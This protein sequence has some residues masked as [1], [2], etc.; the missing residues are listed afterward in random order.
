MRISQQIVLT[1]IIVYIVGYF[2]M[3]IDK[4]IIFHVHPRHSY[5]KNTVRVMSICNVALCNHSVCIDPK[6][7]N[8]YFSCCAD[9]EVW[10]L[11][12]ILLKIMILNLIWLLNLGERIIW[13]MLILV[14]K[15]LVWK[16]TDRLSLWNYCI[17]WSNQKYFKRPRN[18]SKSLDGIIARKI[19]W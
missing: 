17:F 19:V 13:T 4:N 2:D 9:A 11:C 16:T 6:R 8:G 7:L 15:L 1:N 12:M 5:L 3:I 14:S 10:I 18:S